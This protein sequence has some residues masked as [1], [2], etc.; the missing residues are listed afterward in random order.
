MIYDV[1]Y[2]LSHQME[3]AT[4][5]LALSYGPVVILDLD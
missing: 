3:K 4:S 2:Q 1:D 5:F